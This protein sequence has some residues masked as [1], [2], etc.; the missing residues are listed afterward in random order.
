MFEGVFT[1]ANRIDGIEF[2]KV[3]VASSHPSITKMDLSSSDQGELKLVIS[4]A[5][6]SD[7]TEAL[8]IAIKEAC[9]IAD[10]LAVCLSKAVTEPRLTD[11]ALS[12]TIV[13]ESGS[14]LAHH[15]LIQMVP[16]EAHASC[17]NKL[18]TTTLENS[19]SSGFAVRKKS[20]LRI[21]PK[22]A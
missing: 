19:G 1:F 20:V 3:S 21:I 14:D 6:I 15:M 22:H 8:A 11:Q 13:D 2:E 5:E 7:Q 4:M 10:R 16:L 18:G 12:E 17:V 9:R